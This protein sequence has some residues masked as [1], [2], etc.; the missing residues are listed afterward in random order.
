[1]IYTRRKT[2]TKKPQKSEMEWGKKCL[3]S[4]HNFKKNW[5]RMS[6]PNRFVC[7][8]I[9]AQKAQGTCQKRGWTIAGARRPGICCETVSSI[10]AREAVAMESQQHDINK[11]QTMKTPSVTSQCEC[12]ESHK[13]PPLDEELRTITDCWERETQ[14]PLGIGAPSGKPTPGGQ[15]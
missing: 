13:A 1:M 11:T 10:W 14:S 9:H 12:R 4:L 2:N 5:L 6:S 8:V 15:S 3:K 7:S